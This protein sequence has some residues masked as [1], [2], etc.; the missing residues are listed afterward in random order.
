MQFIFFSKR[1]YSLERAGVTARTEAA[2]SRVVWPSSGKELWRLVRE[3]RRA[4]EEELDHD[5]LRGDC[6]IGD[7]VDFRKLQ[8]IFYVIT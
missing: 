2:M 7:K 1:Y 6:T 8:A 3:A 4:S 5:C